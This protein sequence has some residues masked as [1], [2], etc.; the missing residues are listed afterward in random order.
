MSWRLTNED[1]L[2]LAPVVTVPSNHSLL[3]RCCSS[4]LIPP[5]KDTY[6]YLQERLT[7]S[8][9]YLPAPIFHLFHFSIGPS[10]IH[11]AAHP[12]AL[13]NCPPFSH[14]NSTIVLHALKTVATTHLSSVKAHAVLLENP[15]SNRG[16][17]WPMP[18]AMAQTR[19]TQETKDTILGMKLA[20]ARYQDCK[21]VY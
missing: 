7:A 12:L 9:S 8:I 21:I 1:R 15:K 11:L 10:R 19:L 6:A 13:L 5:T 3:H 18:P 4:S 14:T 16:G 17:S 2:E 20:I